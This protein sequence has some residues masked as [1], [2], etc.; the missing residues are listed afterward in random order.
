MQ[1]GP[2]AQVLVGYAQGHRLKKKYAD[3]ALAKVSA[4]GAV[5]ATP[6]MLHSGTVCGVRDPRRDAR[7]TGAKAL[8]V[9]G[10]KYRQTRLSAA[11]QRGAIRA[12]HASLAELDRLGA[13]YWKRTVPNA[14]LA[15]WEPVSEGMSGS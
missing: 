13:H 14:S 3:L 1:V 7:R 10:R 6:A 5:N 9:A 12:V 4:I 15:W 8:A 11:V 2:L